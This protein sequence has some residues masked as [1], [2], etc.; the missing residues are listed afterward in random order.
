MFMITN[1]QDVQT[2]ELFSGTGSFSKVAAEKG[3]LI[4]TYDNCP[5]AKVFPSPATHESRSIL[6]RDITFPPVECGI[7]WA[8]PP[9]EGFSVGSIGR[10][11]HPPKNGKKFEKGEPRI[12]K[13]ERSELA[14]KLLE[15]TIEIIAT[16]KPRYFFIENPVGMCRKVINPIFEKYGLLDQVIHNTISYCKYGDLRMKPTDIWTN[17]NRWI[18][19]PKCKRYRFDK[20]GQ[21]IDKHCH[22]E[23][24][25]R[26]SKTGT[27]GETDYREKSR[28]PRELFIDILS[29]L[30]D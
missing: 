23:V 30:E 22:H 4:A 1:L 27:Q 16:T 7:L 3:M 6:D 17:S 21:I 15:R 19:R 2:I 29:D 8:S 20:N 5:R 11:W 18:P 25:R 13:S 24:A 9:C 26:G 28:I 12:P 10:H 14:L